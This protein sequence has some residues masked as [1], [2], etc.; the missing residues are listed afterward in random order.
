MP[1]AL[2]IGLGEVSDTAQPYAAEHGI[3]LWQLPELAKALQGLPLGA[4][5]AR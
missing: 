3:A 1:D 2:F 5:A 4:N